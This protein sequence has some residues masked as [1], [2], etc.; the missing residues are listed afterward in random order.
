KVF[1]EKL[2]LRAQAL[3]DYA[4]LVLTSSFGDVACGTLERSAAGFRH[5]NNA[6]SLPSLKFCP[7]VFTR[8]FRIATW[9]FKKEAFKCPVTRPQNPPK[10]L[11]FQRG[12]I[13]RRV[14][15]NNV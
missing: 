7:S 14:L 3:S 6:S 10:T 2:E 13:G 8:S 1:P 4:W 9:R 5:V 11:T 12:R 15:P